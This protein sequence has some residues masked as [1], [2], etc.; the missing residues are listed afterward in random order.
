M[1][2]LSS[3]QELKQDAIITEI[4]VGSLMTV[5]TQTTNLSMRHIAGSPFGW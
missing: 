5:F 3:L 2:N 4:Y 1:I